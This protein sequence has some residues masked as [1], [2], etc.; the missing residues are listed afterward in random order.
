MSIFRSVLLVFMVAASILITGCKT[1]IDVIAPKRD[2]TIIYGL[3]EA[4][5]SRQFIRINKAFVGEDSATTLAAQNGIN[6]YSDAELSAFVHEMQVDGIT[7]T[8]KSWSLIK[9]TIYNKQDGNFNSDS[10]VIYYFDA[11]LDV[12]KLYQIECVINVEG[13]DERNVTAIT[14]ILGAPAS[15]GV[16]IE[17]VRLEKPKESA[18]SA[19]DRTKNEVAF[20]NNIN[21]ATSFEVKWSTVNG[22]HLY[23]SYCRLYYRDF[24]VSTGK[25]TLDSVTLSI[26]SKDFENSDEEKSFQNIGTQDFY[27]T[28]GT[29]VDDLDT[30]ISRN[31]KRIVSDT[32]QFFVEVAN[33][34]LSTYIEVNQPISGVV[35]D[36]PE[37]TNVNGGIGIWASR[38]VASTRTNSVNT[39]GRIMDNR[40]MEELLYS[41]LPETGDYTK[42]KSFTRPGRC[43][44]T[45]AGGVRCQ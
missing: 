34:E 6:E 7:K 37:Y 32:L 31:T 30:T 16:G 33:K 45:T 13:E 19:N 40:T 41:N 20:V 29:T 25:A 8:G 28:I 12:T 3:L 26:G 22:G 17:A 15:S 24:D 21:Y 10:N 4:N 5:N 39:S 36:R 42:S 18:T 35:Q 11:I 23:T 44:V 2:V 9:T 27:S 1:D 38:L 43:A 14:D